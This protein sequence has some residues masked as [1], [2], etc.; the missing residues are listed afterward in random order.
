MTTDQFVQEIADALTGLRL[1]KKAKDRAK[2][3]TR[4]REMI[5]EWAAEREDGEA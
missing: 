3:V 2:A 4:V 5:E 1:I